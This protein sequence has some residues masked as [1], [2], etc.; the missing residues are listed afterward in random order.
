MF[1]TPAWAQTSGGGAGIEA[2]FVQIFP[3]ILIVVLFY[4]LLI[5]PQQQR[6]K[7]HKDMVAN[8]RRGD[9]VVTAGGL[10]GKVKTVHDAE[11]ELS[12]EIAKGVEVR[13]VRSTLSD[14]RS[15]TEPAPKES[16]AKEDQGEG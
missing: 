10:V 8:V 15:K 1:S 4:F 9:V 3:L 16:K 2:I 14:V 11:D 7:A 12:V 6:M 13:V 5:R